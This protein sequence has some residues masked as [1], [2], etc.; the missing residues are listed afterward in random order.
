MLTIVNQLRLSDDKIGSVKL[1]LSQIRNIEFGSITTNKND[2]VILF[3][4][5]GN[6]SEIAKNILLNNG[7]KNVVNGIN[8]ENIKMNYLNKNQK[9]LIAINYPYAYSFI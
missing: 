3:C 1:P 8:I 9:F 6:R 4:R 2:E 5:S 7:Y